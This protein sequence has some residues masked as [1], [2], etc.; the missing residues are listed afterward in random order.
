[1]RLGN[2]R[3]LTLD[4]ALAPTFVA[5]DSAALRAT[6]CIVVDVI[7][8]TTSLCVLFER[9]CQRVFIAPGIAEAKAYRDTALSPD[10][11]LALAGESGGIAPQGFDFGNS[12][13][14]FGQTSVMDTQLVFAT[15]NGT[16]ALRAGAGSRA[17][18]AGALRNASAVCAAALAAAAAQHE[19][20]ADAASPGAATEAPLFE[21]EP[22]ILIVCSGRGNR[23]A[24]DDTLCAGYLAGQIV[25]LAAAQGRR[26]HVHEG[27][28]IATAA[29]SDAL[30]DGGL[31]AA[32]A[33]SEAARAVQSI[34]L[35][36][37]LDWCAAID[38]T[39]IVPTVTGVTPGGLLIVE[40]LARA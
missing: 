27:A 24:Y 3:A 23:P 5:A 4:I 30:R 29:A 33:T 16:R 25:R 36:A 35:S 9:G 21:R 20:A 18:F 31:R 1:M 14:E 17:L 39:D 12:P 28:R 15:T 7:R 40:R 32:L 11:P 2:P 13:A 26:A 34:G 38:A 22:D 6:T 19:P 37:D 8:A 10:M